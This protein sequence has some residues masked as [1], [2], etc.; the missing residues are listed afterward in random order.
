MINKI[1]ILFKEVF[2]RKYINLDK[3]DYDNYWITKGDKSRF[4]EKLK[5]ISDLIE[6]NSTVLDIGC[7]NGD[8]LAYIKSQKNIK[9]FGIDISETTI[10]FAKSKGINAWK[11]DITN[12][13]F[14]IDKYDYIIISE[15]IEHL[16]QP[17]IL[18]S[19]IKN[20]FNKSILITIPNTGFLPYRL[21]LLFGQFPIQW[22]YHP[23]EHLRFWTI[24][25]FLWWTK[26]IGFSVTN[27]IPSGGITY[28]NLYKHLPNIFGHITVFVLTKSP[29]SAVSNKH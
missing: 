2:S 29:E 10:N 17:E 14:S 13:N 16:S 15:V 22:N 24:K 26:E 4:P 21:R 19:K 9:A 27:I 3:M 5:I 20:K 23:A 6:N 12:S 18:L 28:F 1:K 7:G 25:D 11:D 8:T